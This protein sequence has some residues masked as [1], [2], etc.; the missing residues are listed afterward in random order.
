[1]KKHLEITTTDKLQ[2]DLKNNDWDIG[3]KCWHGSRIGFPGI[4][5]IYRLLEFREIPG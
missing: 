1:M 3:D 2:F 4:S 5:G